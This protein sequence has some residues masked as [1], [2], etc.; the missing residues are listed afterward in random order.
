MNTTYSPVGE[1]RSGM[2]SELFRTSRGRILFKDP[3]LGTRAVRLLTDDLTGRRYLTFTVRNRRYR[4]FADSVKLFLEQGVWDPEPIHVD[5]DPANDRISNLIPSS[6]DEQRRRASGVYPNPDGGYRAR[7]HIR[8]EDGRDGRLWNVGT[9]ETEEEARAAYHAVAAFHREQQETANFVIRRRPV[10]K[11]LTT[12]SKHGYPGVSYSPTSG[13]IVRSRRADTGKDRQY[14]GAFK[15]ALEAHEAYQT[16][17][18]E[19][20]T[21]EVKAVIAGREA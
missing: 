9:Y 16:W 21:D 20:G 13:Y 19:N 6:G 1:S 10:R 4:A 11:P 7:Y 17:L 8:G 14:I 15:T 12:S 18:M 5:G 2:I 3:D